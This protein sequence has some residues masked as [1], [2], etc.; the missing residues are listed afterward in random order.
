MQGRQ[1]ELGWTVV[2]VVFGLGLAFGH[3]WGKV[4]GGVTDFSQSVAS[5]GFPFPVFFAWCAALTELV[6]GI[7][8]AVGFLT[9][10]VSAMA[11]FTMLVALYQHLIHKGDPFTKAEKAL[12]YLAVFVA[13]SLI[14]A[15]P[16]SVDAKLRRRP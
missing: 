5:L 3:G 15:G 7:L 12:L 1:A 10:P 16:W 9:R 2:R 6:G 8:I 13:L 11:S 14:G 4:S